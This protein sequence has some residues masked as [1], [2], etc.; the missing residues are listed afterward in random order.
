MI[1]NVSFMGDKTAM[2]GLQVATSG[3]KQTDDKT[4][5][6]VTACEKHVNKKISAALPIF[7]KPTVVPQKP[8]VEC[9]GDIEVKP[10]AKHCKDPKESFDFTATQNISIKIPI[11]YRVEVCYDKG[12]FEAA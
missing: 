7:I 3:P 1:T 10:G 12:C 9:L 11:G 8:H 2:Q 5:H 4:C 6:D